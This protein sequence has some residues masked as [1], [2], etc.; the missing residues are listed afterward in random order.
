MSAS[1]Q[2]GLNLAGLQA[3]VVALEAAEEA[4]HRALSEQ[5]DRIIGGEEPA[6]IP[7]EVVASIPSE[8]EL[9]AKWHRDLGLPERKTDL[10][11]QAAA[12]PSS[13]SA[14]S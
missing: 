4:V 2:A 1:I 10:G 14:S 3:A 6:V 9:T 5:A 13:D 7:E 11:D 8:V 12:P